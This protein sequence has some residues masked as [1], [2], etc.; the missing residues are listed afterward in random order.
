[1]REINKYTQQLKILPEKIE[2]H[3]VR[4]CVTVIRASLV[5]FFGQLQQLGCGGS[6]INA[7]FQLN[8]MIEVT[9]QK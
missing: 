9:E 3:V 4:N 5:K 8:F 7:V 6:C 2:R 1:V